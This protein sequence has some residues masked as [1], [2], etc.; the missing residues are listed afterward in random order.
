[1]FRHPSLDVFGM[2]GSLCIY[3]AAS[4]GCIACKCMSSIAFYFSRIAF[5]A[6]AKLQSLK[7]T[8]EAEFKYD[9]YR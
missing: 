9:R 4:A 3:Y 5:I 2:I 8:A 1:M 6:A 7:N